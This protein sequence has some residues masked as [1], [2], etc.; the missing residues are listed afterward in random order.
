ML[1]TFTMTGAIAADPTEA[2]APAEANAKFEMVIGTFPDSDSI[3]VV[4]P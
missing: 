1:A 2:V 4:S 3:Y